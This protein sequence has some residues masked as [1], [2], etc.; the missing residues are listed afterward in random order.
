MS[1]YAAAGAFSPPRTENSSMTP[2]FD[3][4]TERGIARYLAGQCSEEEAFELRSRMA[5]DP[6]LAEYVA[7]LERTWELADALPRKWSSRTAWET[8][9]DRIEQR[10][11]D[12]R[13]VRDLRLVSPRFALPARSALLRIA[14]SV[15]LMVGGGAAWWA[16]SRP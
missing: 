5:A 13:S 1:G 4:E 11:Q 9:R 3:D 12:A 15:V 16:V 7:K 6:D 10:E 2:R 14:A 8:V